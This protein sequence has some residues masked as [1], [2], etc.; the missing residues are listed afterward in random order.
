MGIWVRL[1]GCEFTSNW[2]KES[3]SLGAGESS[4]SPLTPA[5]TRGQ[6]S[7]KIATGAQPLS[8]PPEPP[9]PRSL[10]EG[11]WPH[12]TSSHPAPP[13]PCPPS[14]ALSAV[15]DEDIPPS[16][17]PAPATTGTCIPHA[18]PDG[19]TRAAPT[20]VQTL[21]GTRWDSQIKSPIQRLREGQL[22]FSGK[23]AHYAQHSV[24]EMIIFVKERVGLPSSC[25]R[26][27]KRSARL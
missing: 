3:W 9:C 15:T 17:G 13:W 2:K 16:A 25:E 6:V 27:E 5:S 22:G 4:L 23:A 8:R 18:G 1:T 24:G 21:R 10:G 26:K 19:L 14:P 11:S 20:S 7:L 12:R